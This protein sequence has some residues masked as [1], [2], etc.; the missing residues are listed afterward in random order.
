[1]LCRH[2]D[3]ATRRNKV[4]QLYALV[5]STHIFGGRVLT[6]ESACGTKH[7]TKFSNNH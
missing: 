1:M 7:G 4:A 2:Y 6:F 3:E 5:R